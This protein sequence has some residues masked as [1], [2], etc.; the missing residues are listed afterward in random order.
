MNL[1]NV[2]NKHKLIKKRYY[3]VGDIIHVH[4]LAFNNMYTVM[5]CKITNIKINFIV[6][7]CNDGYKNK[8]R[9]F[10]RLHP[11]V[12]NPCKIKKS[13]LNEYFLTYGCKI[14]YYENKKYTIENKEKLWV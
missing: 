1:R 14:K 4:E 3:S 7:R 11:I 10:D 5:I 12:D 8:G 6:L 9:I 2:E 13:W